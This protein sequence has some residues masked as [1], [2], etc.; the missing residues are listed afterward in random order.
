MS[1]SRLRPLC[2]VLFTVA[3]AGSACGQGPEA[4]PERET[5]AQSTSPYLGTTVSDDPPTRG[6]VLAYGLPGETNSFNPTVAQWPAYSMQVARALF[7]TMYL[8]D[9]DGNVRPNLVQRNEHNEDY[10]V[11][12][13]TLRPGI[14]FHNGKKLTAADVI[15][16]QDYNRASPVLGSAYARTYIERSEVIDELT[17]RSYSSRP[18]PTMPHAGTTQLAVVA[19]PDWLTSDDWAHPIGTGPFKIEQWNLGR[20]M[21]LVRNPDYWQSDRWGN[22]LPYLDKLEFQ[23]IPSDQERAEALRDGRIDI[24]MQTLTTPG[25]AS[26]RDQCRAGRFQCFSDEKVETPEDLVVLN[27]SKPPFNDIDARR[28]LA[29][30]VDRQDLVR[31]LMGDLVEPADGIYSTSSKWYSPS[32]YPQFDPVTAARL[33]TSVKA[34]NRGQFKFE[35]QAPATEDAARVTTY[36]QN[37]WKRAGIDVTI[38]SMDNQKKIINMVTGGYQAALTQ[39]FDAA[40]PV[41]NFAFFDPEQANGPLTLSFPRL[42]DP[43]VSGLIEGFLRTADSRVWRAVNVRIMDRINELVP[44]I[45]LDHAP[46]TILAQPNV[47]NIVQATLPTGEMAQDFLLGSH[48]VAQIWIKRG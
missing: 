22:K 19:D 41:V 8:Y 42:K 29:M 9:A 30:S 36:L 48:P 33:V 2:F 43:E 17:F 7:D 6:G 25:I 44:Y 31:Q 38:S 12:T 1:L 10:T 26:I 15:K 23:V 13:T 47:V 5:P 4:A 20:T 34:R 11:W 27:T 37:A 24:M 32:A 28:A 40:H 18:W 46:R 35:L 14:R 39:Q 16:T 3:L 45:W 21:V